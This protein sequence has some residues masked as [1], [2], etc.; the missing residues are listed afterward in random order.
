[1]FSLASGYSEKS[2][3]AAKKNFAASLAAYS[4]FSY[5][6]LI[7]DRHNGNLLI[8]SEG[9]IIH[10]DFGFLLSIAPGGSFSLEAYIQISSTYT[11]TYIYTHTLTDL[12]SLK[13]T[14]IHTYFMYFFKERILISSTFIHTDI[15]FEIMCTLPF[16]Y[17]PPRSSLPT[18]W[19]MCWAG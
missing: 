8:D 19:W 15:T 11:L 12:H 5:I 17:R 13:Y 4:L 10:I 2:L 1:M 9:H 3:L 6:L 7:K 18:R 14:Y 16:H